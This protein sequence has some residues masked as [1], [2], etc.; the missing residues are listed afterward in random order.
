MPRKYV[1]RKKRTTTKRRRKYTRKSLSFSKAPIPNKFA[2]KLR[3]SE[4]V[5]VDPAAGGISGVHVWNASSCYDPNTTGVGHQ[6]RGFDQWMSM[7]D[8]FVVVGCKITATF[9]LVNQTI[10]RAATCGISLKDSPATNPDY[11]DYMEGRN[12]T[13]RLITGGARSDARTVTLSKTYSPRKFLSITK[14]LSSQLIRGSAQSNPSENAYFHTWIAPAGTVDMDG[15]TI[16]V[17][18]DYLVVF[19]EPKNPAQS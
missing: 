16:Q 17:V 2:A 3:Y 10:D 6:P 18:I 14:P 15:C 1:S 12:V 4:Y 5:T 8:H 19:V 13:S 7:F 9:C 11:N